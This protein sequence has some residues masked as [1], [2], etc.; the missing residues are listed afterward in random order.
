MPGLF[1][2]GNVADSAIE[3]G[4]LSLGMTIGFALTGG[5]PAGEAVCRVTGRYPPASR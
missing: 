4:I 2:A 3:P 1:A 5:Q